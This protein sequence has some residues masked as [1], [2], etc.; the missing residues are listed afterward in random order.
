MAQRN[1]SQ[2]VA[3]NC[4]TIEYTQEDSLDPKTKKP[5]RKIIIN[6]ECDLVPRKQNEG[7]LTLGK[8]RL[9]QIIQ[10][11]MDLFLGQQRKDKET[12]RARIERVFGKA[13]TELD[14]LSKGIYEDTEI[15]NLL[16]YTSNHSLIY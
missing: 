7:K 8:T 16:E 13:T 15:Q 5:K 3:V 14:R 9:K 2:L 11:E 12:K 10:E 1:T 4:K 6:K